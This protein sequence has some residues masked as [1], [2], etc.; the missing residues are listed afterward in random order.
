MFC[1]NCGKQ[2]SDNSKFCPACGAKQDVQQEVP[3]QTTATHGDQPNGYPVNQVSQEV[4]QEVPVQTTVNPG[5]QP[6]G[7]P[8]NQ[9]PMPA[10]NPNKKSNLGVKITV[11]VAVV[12]VLVAGAI[13]AVSVFSNM[14]AKGA[15]NRLV[16][17][18]NDC[19]MEKIIDCTAYS[20]FLDED[21]YEDALDAFGEY[22]DKFDVIKDADVEIDVE[23]KSE[24]DITDD[25]CDYDEDQ[26][27]K[28]F[29]QESFEETDNY[30]DQEVQ[31]VK[32]LRVK[33]TCDY[34]EDYE[35][36]V[37]DTLDG[38]EDTEKFTCIKIDGDWYLLMI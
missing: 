32:E 14:G 17:A 6:N 24:K 5:V 28:E 2:L 35:D 37:E 19:D 29:Y 16:D 7:Y 8:V 30:D 11:L 23:F 22:E 18:F 33:L 15:V 21:D 12:A 34:D 3:V 31:A 27:W 25:D 9:A 13:I 26:T 36:E 10:N 38:I 20:L 1:Q 4:G